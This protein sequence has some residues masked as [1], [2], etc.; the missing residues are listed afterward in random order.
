MTI[1]VNVHFFYQTSDFEDVVYTSKLFD[2]VV[3]TYPDTIKCHSQNKPITEAFRPH[4]D[5]LDTPEEPIRE[6]LFVTLSSGYK[7]KEVLYNLYAFC[8]DFYFLAEYL[9]LWIAEHFKLLLK[10]QS[11]SKGHQ[12]LMKKSSRKKISSY[13]VAS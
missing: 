9:S 10:V 1:I 12:K 4:S 5:A 2:K 8:E 6:G 7:S 11:F 13:S 3:E